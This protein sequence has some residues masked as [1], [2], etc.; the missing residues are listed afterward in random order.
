MYN[1][2]NC[3]LDFSQKN[4]LAY[5]VKQRTQKRYSCSWNVHHWDVHWKPNLGIFAI[6]AGDYC[7]WPGITCKDCEVTKI[8][9]YKAWNLCMHGL[10]DST[11]QKKEMTW[12]EI[13]CDLSLFSTSRL[14]PDMLGG[15]CVSFVASCFPFS[16]ISCRTSREPWCPNGRTWQSSGKWFYLSHRSR[17]T[18]QSFVP[19]P[20]WKFWGFAEQEWKE[21]SNPCR[22]QMFKD[23]HCDSLTWATRPLVATF[24]CFRHSP[25]W[26][27]FTLTTPWYLVTSELSKPPRSW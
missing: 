1:S 16:Y 24:E 9:F 22:I 3:W 4:L 10:C 21:M 13:E 2:G 12:N 14:P 26:H 7:S 17:E 18:L 15:L 27:T 20:S 5:S 19:C 11:W 23:V 25:I 8:S 6:R